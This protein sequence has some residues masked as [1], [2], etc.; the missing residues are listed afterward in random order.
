MALGGG[1]LISASNLNGPLVNLDAGESASLLEDIDEGLAILG[2][3]VEGLLKEDHTTE[4][5]EGTR[6]AEEELTEGTAVLLNVLDID[7]GKALANS[8]SGLISSKDTL[9]RGANVGSVLDELV[10]KK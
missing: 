8:A 3:L 5:L 6:G 1:L 9:A 7:A 10:C 2:L 4:V